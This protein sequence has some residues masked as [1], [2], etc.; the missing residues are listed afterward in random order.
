MN[1]SICLPVLWT[2]LEF[3]H[4]FIARRTNEADRHR[5]SPSAEARIQRRRKISVG[6]RSNGRFV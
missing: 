2:N 3:G 1:D 5:R 4:N 6:G